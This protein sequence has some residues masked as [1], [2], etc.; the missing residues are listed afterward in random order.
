MKVIQFTVLNQTSSYIAAQKKLRLIADNLNASPTELASDSADDLGRLVNDLN[1]AMEG[2]EL[3]D[4][5]GLTSVMVFSLGCCMISIF[6]F[7]VPYSRRKLLGQFQ[8]SNSRS[9]SVEQAAMERAIADISGAADH[10]MDYIDTVSNRGENKQSVD[11]LETQFD[12]IIT[13]SAHIRALSRELGASQDSFNEVD[14]LLQK[15][16][17]Q[18]GDSA[19][20]ASATRLEWNTMGN[21]LRQLREHHDKS[22][23]ISDKVVKLQSTSAERLA[24]S[25]E[26][27]KIHNNH[28]ENVRTNLNRLF[29]NSRS[30]YRFLDSMSQSIRVSKDDVSAASDL[31]K[32]LSERA[33]A[34][35]NIIDVIDDIAEQTNQLALNAS[36]EAARA[37][38]QGQGFAVVAGE[39]RNLAARS[40]T[41]TKS[42]TDLLGTIQEEAEQASQLLAKSNE[43]VT[44]TYSKIRDV[45]Q[46]YRESLLLSRHALTGL[47][48]LGNDVT[49]HFT[50]LKSIERTG[51]DIR[52]LS[53]N[54]N[55]LLEEHSQMSTLIN[56][57]G[58]QLTVHSDRMSRLL[59]RQYYEINHAQKLLS[60]TVSSVSTIKSK[61]EQ[62]LSNT[63][64]IKANLD[65]LYKDSMS[66]KTRAF[67][68]NVSAIKNI[69]VLKSSSRTLTL[70][71]NPAL[72][73]SLEEDYGSDNDSGSA[74]PGTD[75]KT[76]L[77]AKEQ[78]VSA[79]KTPSASAIANL[80]GEDLFIGDNSKSTDHRA[81]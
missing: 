20:F 25:L 67:N 34:I 33:E 36:I 23:S 30:G 19:H 16:S 41:A 66:F 29:E 78:Q 58:N 4:S 55:S 40:S 56:T 27:I 64:N 60:L 10:L 39:V 63:E 71:Q 3:V 38:E 69:Q 43:A 75:Q 35:V 22:K 6:S 49:N 8:F 76:N 50:D 46:S 54:M 17:A 13:L 7:I 42:I 21:K 26:F 5:Y 31:V 37:G 12:E 52:K 32:G 53:N 61:V 62:S 18:C 81:S 1:Q 80:P 14:K 65:H 70:L 51:N 72:G 48:V 45:D 44:E 28:S 15:L 59:L 11:S 24:K 79:P 73:I 2:N 68:H 77:K 74:D 9:S 57:E 47:D